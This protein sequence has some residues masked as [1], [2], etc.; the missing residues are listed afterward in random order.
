MVDT[1]KYNQFCT[2]AKKVGDKAESMDETVL[3]VADIISTIFDD[4]TGGVLGRNVGPASRIYWEI[5]TRRT[6]TFLFGGRHEIAQLVS[7]PCGWLAL[8]DKL[9]LI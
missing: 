8:H 6:A 9:M 2:A 3:T 1:P 7:E 4:A 5:F